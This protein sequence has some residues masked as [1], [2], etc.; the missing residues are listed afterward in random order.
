MRELNKKGGGVA[1]ARRTAD[2]FLGWGVMLGGLLGAFQLAALPL[3][4]VFSPVA[5][6][7]QAARAP[8]VIGAALQLIN[9][10]T[11]IGEGVMVG[12]GSF[13]ALAVGQIVATAALLLA[14][15]NATSLAGVWWCFWLFNG[16]R[17]A[18]VLRHH[19]VSGPLATARER[20]SA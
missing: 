18:N 11:F 19:F 13:G 14:L 1:A 12:T 16:V 7:Q 15:R 10:V 6:V 3:L 9:G 8:S 17:F 5:D 2:R 20:A 4:G